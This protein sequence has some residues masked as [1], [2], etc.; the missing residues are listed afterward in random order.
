[1]VSISGCQAG[2][3]GLSLARSVCF[4]KM[5]FGK[6]I[7]NLTPPVLLTDS[8]TAM[9]CVIMS[10]N[11]C[12]ISL[13][14]GFARVHCKSRLRL[15]RLARL[16]SWEQAQKPGFPDIPQWKPNTKSVAYC[17]YSICLYLES[18]T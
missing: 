16:L 14:F 13:A 15:H 5:E 8:T 6:N 4:R 17:I 3:P 1:M 12:K 18:N 7:T 10:D 9:I 2:S 11:A